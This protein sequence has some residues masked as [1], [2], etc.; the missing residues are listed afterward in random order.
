MPKNIQIDTTTEAW[1]ASIGKDQK[2]HIGW[3]NN[4]VRGFGLR[5]MMFRQQEKSSEGFENTNL[6]N[7]LHNVGVFL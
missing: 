6:I 7:T 1:I 3:K 5:A 4:V 2:E